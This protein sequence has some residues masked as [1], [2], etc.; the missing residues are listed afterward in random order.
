MQPAASENPD[1]IEISRFQTLLWK[2]SLLDL[3]KLLSN[4]NIRQGIQT[5]KQATRCF[6]YRL[7]TTDIQ[8][9]LGVLFGVA[10]QKK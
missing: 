10:A 8:R 9:R 6:I 7:D 1:G 3:L 2:R 4:A 5:G